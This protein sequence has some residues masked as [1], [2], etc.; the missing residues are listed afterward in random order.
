VDRL[1]RKTRR[2]L[3][4]L[5]KEEKRRAKSAKRKLARENAKRATKLVKETMDSIED[6][7]D[8]LMRQKRKSSGE[9]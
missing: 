9:I 6:H 4:L 5:L 1:L 2:R 8:L 7:H 3:L